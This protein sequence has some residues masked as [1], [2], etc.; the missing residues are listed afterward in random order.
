LVGVLAK[1]IHPTLAYTPY[2]CYVLSDMIWLVW[3]ISKAY[4]PYACLDGFLASLNMLSKI[5]QLNE[6]WKDKGYQIGL[7]VGLN[8]GPALAVINDERFDYF[9][10][11]VNIAH[12][13]KDWRK[14]AK[15]GSR[16]PFLTLKK[17]PTNCQLL[18][19]KPNNIQST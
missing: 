4:T 12:E 13:F 1:L 18:V 10:Q 16:N 7:K 2:A 8:E 17:S 14:P 15:F 3:C 11:S 9:G 19:N 5:E 6:I